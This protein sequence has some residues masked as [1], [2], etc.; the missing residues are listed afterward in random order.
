M[1][2]KL[3]DLDGKLIL[4]AGGGG[5]LGTRMALELARCGGRVIVVDREKQNATNVADQVNAE[6]PG[7]GFAY[8][9][10]VT[11]ESEMRDLDADVRRNI[12]EVEVLINNAAAKGPGFF[13]PFENFPMEEWDLVM[14]VNTTGV[15]LGCKIFGSSMAQRGSGSIINTLSIY[16]IAAPDQR[17]YEGSMYEGHAI[18]TPAVYSTSKAAVWGLTKYLA[19][20][21]GDKGVR[22]NAITPGGVSSGQNKTFMD[23]YSK[24]VPMG[25]MAKQD[26]MNGA[27]VFLA[28]DASSY[29][30]GQ[31]IVVDG[32]LTVW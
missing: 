29:V 12:G 25:R 26:E 20:Y 17:I 1:K 31:N 32:G 23:L 21:W 9:V 11:S 28:S 22:V 3:F 16:G 6:H 24:R 4:L 2:S 30:T 10:D 18:N 19:T 5:I 15:M 14:G 7:C 27:I 8:S 13:Q